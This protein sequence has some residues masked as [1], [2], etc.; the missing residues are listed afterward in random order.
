MPKTELSPIGDIIK[1]P[2]L[3]IEP[4]TPKKPTREEVAA[5]V[6]RYRYLVDPKE[7]YDHYEKVGWDMRSWKAVLR[8]WHSQ[9]MTRPAV[10]TVLAFHK[11][12]GEC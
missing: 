1:I 12:N 9:E 7:F 11:K 2:K 10:A 4:P 8:G 5:H 6:Q 3:R